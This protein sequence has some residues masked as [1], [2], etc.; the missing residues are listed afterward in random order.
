M[1][2][3][4]HP[5]IQLEEDY[6]SQH[7]DGKIPILDL[8]VWVREEEHQED[9]ERKVELFY[10]YYRKPMSNWLLIPAN[11]ALS[12]ATKRTALTQYGLRILRNSKPEIG[13]QQRADMLSVFM[14]RM[15]DSGYGE[16]YRLETIQSILRGWDR[17]VEEERSGG[18]PIN[19]LKTYQERE[20]RESR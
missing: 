5:M 1:A 20:S 17:M 18:R 11:S 15:R 13:W 4:I 14:E 16:Q 6:P 2:D 19:R 3:S 9:R 7:P 8:K 12:A 10:H